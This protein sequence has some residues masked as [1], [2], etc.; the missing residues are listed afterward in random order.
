MKKK[1]IILLVV[2]LAA[3]IIFTG[4]GGAQEIK[5][6]EP[7]GT[8]FEVTGTCEAKIEGDKL[9]VFGETNMMDGTNG[10]IGVLNSDGT[11]IEEQK[12]TKQGDNLRAEFLIE[13]DWPEIVYGYIMFDTQKSSGQPQEVKNAYGS[14]FENLSGENVI[15][16]QQGVIA[17]FQSE[18]VEVK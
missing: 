4:C 6:P 8:V 10:I 3:A 16:N 14:K 9:V 12:V 18:K 1:L 13:G 2:V 11:R 17:I 7:V 5:K 15:W